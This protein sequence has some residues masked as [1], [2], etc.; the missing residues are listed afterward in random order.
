MS[1]ECVVTYE[2]PLHRCSVVSAPRPPEP[3]IAT[4]EREKLVVGAAFDDAS[5]VHHGDAVGGGGLGEPVGDGHGG[6]APGRPLRR[7]P[8]V[9]RRAPAMPPRWLSRG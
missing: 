6:A 9:R 8:Q 4:L 5:V 1:S 3:R 7:R 2:Q